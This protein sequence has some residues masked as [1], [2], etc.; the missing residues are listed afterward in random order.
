MKSPCFQQNYLPSYLSLYLRFYLPS[1]LQ[2]LIR[3]NTPDSM[4]LTLERRVSLPHRP[5]INVIDSFDCAFGPRQV[6]RLSPHRAMD[7]G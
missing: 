7:V 5:H 6:C 1:Y 2:S 3:A 4:G